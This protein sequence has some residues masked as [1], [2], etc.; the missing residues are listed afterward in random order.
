M[1]STV[2]HELS[3]SAWTQVASGVKT[4]AIQFRDQGRCLIHVGDTEPAA[5][6][7]GIIIA[8]GFANLPSSFTAAGLPEEASVW[9]KSPEG[10]EIV[11]L[12]Y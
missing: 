1:A 3:S 9:C 10:S 4:V 5:D 6:A 12:S 8:T 7:P 2:T 11:V